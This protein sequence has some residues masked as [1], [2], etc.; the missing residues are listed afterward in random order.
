MEY[1]MKK[2]IKMLAKMAAVA[3]LALVL[4]T[5]ANAQEGLS[6]LSWS[7]SLPSGNTKDFSQDNESFRGIT[8]TYRY[9]PQPSLSF[10]VYGGW[11]VFN[12]ETVDTI[13]VDQ[14]EFKGA[15]TGKQWRYIN[16]F[17][18]MANVHFYSGRP[19]RTQLFL[20]MN[21]G[22]MIIE[23]RLDINIWAIKSNKWHWAVA[24]EVGVNLPL[25]YNTGLA[26]SAIYH[27][28]FSAGEKLVGE[29]SKHQYLSIN[30]GVSFNHSF[31]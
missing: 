1:T 6:I 13:E 22:G 14:E 21:A 20:G 31:F 11:H 12:G 4:L 25:G 19:G 30:I 27:Y 8:F 16:S 5:P 15:V 17:P 2:T 24:P 9:F 10:G 7:I 18:I 29:S 28:A 23:E 26:I 3:V